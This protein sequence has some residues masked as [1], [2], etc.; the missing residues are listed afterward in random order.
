MPVMTRKRSSISHL[1]NSLDSS[2]LVESEKSLATSTMTTT[3][4]TTMTTTTTTKRKKKKSLMKNDVDDNYNQN[5][6][7]IGDD[8]ININRTRKLVE[9]SIT[10]TPTTKEK[11]KTKNK[12]T[13]TTTTNDDSANI[14]SYPVEIHGSLSSSSSSLLLSEIILQQMIKEADETMKV[15]STN[16]VKGST[17]IGC[18][19]PKVRQIMKDIMKHYNNHHMNYDRNQNPLL[20][21]PSSLHLYE[22]GMKLI[23]HDASDVKLAGMI[24]LSE[25]IP[26]HEIASISMIDQLEHE[27]FIQNQNMIND[28][29]TSDWFSIRVLQPIA[30]YDCNSDEHHEH[31]HMNHNLSSY[32]LASRILQWSNKKHTTV[33]HRRCGIVPFVH[34][35]TKVVASQNKNKN[36]AMKR[37]L[38]IEFTIQLINACEQN[39]LSSPLERFTQTGIAWVLRYV[40]ASYSSSRS[41]SSVSVSS[42][43]L[44]STPP[45]D[46]DPKLEALFNLILLLLIRHHLSFHWYWI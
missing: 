42:V 23:K 44:D 4:T 12:I 33:W 17:W 26:I 38:P 31:D 36:K 9:T 1:M 39:L 40:L 20:L 35:T 45:D 3:T 46:K 5:N 8:D 28:W 30:Y 41:S 6:T 21:S 13:T 24:L 15:W 16:Y 11:K 25:Y 19:T 34:H 7:M 37:Y 29:S 32:P 22:E 14:S 2:E 18:K 27:L 43:S 10:T